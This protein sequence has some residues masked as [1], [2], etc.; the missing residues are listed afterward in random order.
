MGCEQADPGPPGVP[1]TGWSQA[2]ARS[3]EVQGRVDRADGG[4]WSR[5]SGVLARNAAPGAIERDTVSIT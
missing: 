2:G 3:P 5:A 4:A 1:I